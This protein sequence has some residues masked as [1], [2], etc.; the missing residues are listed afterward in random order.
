MALTQLVY[1]M[2]VNLQ[3]FSQFLGLINQYTETNDA[4]AASSAGDAFATDADYWR[5]VQKSLVQSQWARLYRVRAVSVIAMLDPK[6]GD[7]PGVAEQQVGAML[8][9]AVAHRRASRTGAARQ[10]A[11]HPT[12]RS[13]SRSAGPHRRTRAGQQKK[14]GV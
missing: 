4:T 2:G 7:A 8:Y 13:R 10:V 11:S 14:R 9:P 3:E 12:T 6:Y 5:S 1:Q